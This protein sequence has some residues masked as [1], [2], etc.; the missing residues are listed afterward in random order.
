[1]AVK[2]AG[3]DWIVGVGLIFIAA[4]LKAPPHLRRLLRHHLQEVLKISLKWPFAEQA[5]AVTLTEKHT[6][7]F[8][9]SILASFQCKLHCSVYRFL[10]SEFP[11][12]HILPDSFH[13]FSL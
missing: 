11:S 12:P 10:L 1:M 8:N 13:P 3:E 5:C 6:V 7:A 9:V 2:I 4:L